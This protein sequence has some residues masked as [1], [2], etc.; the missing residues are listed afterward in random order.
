ME[1]KLV[2]KEEIENIV[3]NLE[4]LKQKCDSMIKLFKDEKNILKLEDN[5]SLSQQPKVPEKIKIKAFKKEGPNLADIIYEKVDLPTF[6]ATV[7]YEIIKDFVEFGG[8]RPRD[9]V[10]TALNNAKKRFKK[11]GKG[12][13][14]KIE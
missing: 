14:K 11:V 13:Y 4:L 3:Q 6:T 1:Y 12:L 5:I 7:A 9:S 10:R 8:H 2:N